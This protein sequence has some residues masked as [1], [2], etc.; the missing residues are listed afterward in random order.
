MNRIV[1][2]AIAALSLSACTSS[3][4]TVEQPYAGG[5]QFTAAS[6]A[7]ARSSVA[8]DPDDLTYTHRALEDA[9][10][11]GQSPVFAPGQQLTIRWRYVGF[12]EGS[13]IGRWLAPGVAGGSKIVLEADFMD[14]AGQ[15]LSTVRSQ[16]E[17]G[18]GL[19]GG[20]GK[21]GIDKAVE[22]IA[23]YAAANFR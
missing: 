20:T 12:D 15:V 2:A 5:Q 14:Q 10:V 18:A 16:A 17:V 21:S 4:L 9:L 6:V 19:I 3:M 1:F 13:R 23:D 22:E 8:I 11:S 7:Q